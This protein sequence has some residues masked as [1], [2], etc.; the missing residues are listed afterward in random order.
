LLRQFDA[1]GV[2]RAAA[3]FAGIRRHR[4]SAI[5]S[6]VIDAVR[7]QYHHG[8]TGAPLHQADSV[9]WQQHIIA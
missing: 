5:T 6:H 4:I 7:G 8:I 9:P 2:T 1:V 3:S